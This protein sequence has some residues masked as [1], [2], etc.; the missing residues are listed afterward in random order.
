MAFTGVQKAKIRLYLG[1]QDSYRFINLRFESALEVCSP[2]GQTEVIAILT[3][4]DTLDAQLDGGVI[5]AAGVKRV[6]EVEFFDPKAKGSVVR[7]RM[8]EL[9]WRM[10]KLLGVDD[11]CQ[12]AIS[13][14]GNGSYPIKLG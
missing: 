7:A 6:D 8:L 3:R 12:P 2:E 11:I 4:L 10:A 5:D 14:G 1:Q 13:G 9:A